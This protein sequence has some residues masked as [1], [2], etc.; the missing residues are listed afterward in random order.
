MSISL[1]GNDALGLDAYEFTGI[2]L[3]DGI[4]FLREYKLVDGEELKRNE[5]PIFE[6]EYV[7]S[8]VLLFE[9]QIPMFVLEALFQLS[10]HDDDKEFKDLVWPL[11]RLNDASLPNIVPNASLLNDSRHL[12]GLVHSVEC[13]SFARI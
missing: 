3:L 1:L 9:N 13:F 10:N 12:L 2:L 5:N 4:E 11:L 8:H 7:A 6:S